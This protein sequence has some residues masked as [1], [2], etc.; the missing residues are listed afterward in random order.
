MEKFRVVF[1]LDE[2]NPARV[3]LV[4]GNIA[5]L[6]ADLTD[7]GVEV[8][9]VANSDGITAFLKTENELTRQIQSLAAKGVRFCLCANSMRQRGLTQGA[10]VEAAEVVP[11]GVSELVKKQ[12]LGWAYIRP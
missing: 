11:S 4:L 9:L 3:N 10:F 12:A 2:S 5:N 6:L 7:D 8:E 1:H